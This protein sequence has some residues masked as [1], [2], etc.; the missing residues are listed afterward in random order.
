MRI[1]LS[2]VLSCICSCAMKSGLGASKSK[3]EMEV[4]LQEG[5]V[6]KADL[7]THSVTVALAVLTCN[8]VAF[9]AGDP[10]DDLRTASFDFTHRPNWKEPWK[11]ST[12]TP[13][14]WFPSCW[15][16]DHIDGKID[17]LL[18]KKLKMDFPFGETYVHIVTCA[19]FHGESVVWHHI[20]PDNLH[21]PVASEGH[22]TS[23]RSRP[24]D[25]PGAT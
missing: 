10:D 7:H 20:A 2:M 9:Y 19:S 14:K 22:R 3:A 11:S 1:C 5:H 21:N 8:M 6:Q 17:R 25:E 13:A 23:R 18:F 4:L 12:P 24:A 16:V 15:C